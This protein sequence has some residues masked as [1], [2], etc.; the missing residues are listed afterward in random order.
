[1]K[2]LWNHVIF[3]LHRTFWIHLLSSEFLVAVSCFADHV[4]IYKNSSIWRKYRCFPKFYD[5]VPLYSCYHKNNSNLWSVIAIISML[6]LAC[7]MPKLSG[8]K[9]EINMIS[10]LIWSKSSK[11]GKNSLLCLDLPK[12][13]HIGPE[14]YCEYCTVGTCFFI[15]TYIYDPDLVD[16]IFQVLYET[17]WNSK[18]ET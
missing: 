14:F 8:L 9:I 11:W 12:V 10:L 13:F 15:V 4:L 7:Y 2:I 3:L 6:Y 1:M 17:V 5:F 16:N 18:A